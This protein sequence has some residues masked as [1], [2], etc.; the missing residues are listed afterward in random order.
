MNEAAPRRRFCFLDRGETRV[1]D[2]FAANRLNWADRA[3]L[4]STDRTGCYDIDRVLSGGDNLGPIEAAEV[5]DIAGHRLV[6]LQCHIGL[7]TISLAGR[8]ATATGLDFSPE[9]IMAARDFAA[10]SGREVRFV[11]ADVYD[12]PAALG[13]RYEV[14]YVTWGTVTWL[15]DIFR[16]AQVVADVL[17]PGGFLYFADTHPCAAALEQVDG[18]LVPQYAWRTPR[19][20]PLAFD[21]A[22]TY[23]G[24]EREIANRRCYNWIHPLSDIINALSQAGLALEWLHEHDRLPYRLFPMMVPA[25]VD[26]KSTRLNSSHNR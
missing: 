12:A 21:D 11:Q 17:E 15:P 18:N 19:E 22:T 1:E 25:D 3:K 2:F 16:W 24:D 10:R 9:A 7:D 23:T 13:E 5:G 6:H 4:H 26:R 20:S 14:A 8:G